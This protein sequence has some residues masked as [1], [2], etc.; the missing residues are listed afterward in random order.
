MRLY[1][2]K[3]LPRGTFRS[4]SGHHEGVGPG[5]NSKKSPEYSSYF[6]MLLRCYTKTT[7]GYYAYGGRGVRV[8]QRWVD[9]FEHF[10]LDL[11]PR[12]D[13]HSLDRINP[14]GNYTP[15]NCR[16]ASAS[17]QATNKRRKA[18]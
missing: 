1:T 5:R 6:G 12:P 4:V 15:S 10:L 7:N 18:A 14:D 8:C 3:K 17:I 2:G 16:W 9:S 13:G 11:G